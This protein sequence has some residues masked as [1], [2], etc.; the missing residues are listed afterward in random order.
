MGSFICERIED[1]GYEKVM[2][3]VGEG[4]DFV[5]L[6][7]YIIIGIVFERKNVKL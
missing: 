1:I 6:K 3:R 2:L 4:L 5:E 7:V